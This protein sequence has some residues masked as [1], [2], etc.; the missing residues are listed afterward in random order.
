MLKLVSISLV[1]FVLTV[2]VQIGHQAQAM[3]ASMP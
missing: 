3:L 2:G 1:A